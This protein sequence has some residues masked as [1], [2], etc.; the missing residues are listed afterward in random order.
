MKINQ[1]WSRDESYFLENSA[2]EPKSHSP[3]TRK[4]VDLSRGSFESRSE[5]E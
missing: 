3:I 2:E 4:V 1:R 5:L